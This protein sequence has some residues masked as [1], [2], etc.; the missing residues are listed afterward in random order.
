[1]KRSSLLTTA[2][3]ELL[4]V[5]DRHDAARAQA[6]LGRAL[7]ASGDFPTAEL[8]LRG[9]MEE[10][11]A[12]GSV[13]WRARTLEWL[14]LTARDRH[15]PRAAREWYEQALAG[16]LSVSPR[17]TQRLRDRIRSLDEPPGGS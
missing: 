10:F 9:A 6:L 8:Q 4:A 11:G 3:R 15:D 14:G 2:H 5:C 16:Y 13:A 1:M 7:A 12:T 17:D